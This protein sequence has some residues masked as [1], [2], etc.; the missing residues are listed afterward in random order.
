MDLVVVGFFPLFRNGS[1]H[2]YV[3]AAAGQQTHQPFTAESAQ[4]GAVSQSILPCCS[5]LPRGLLTK[6]KSVQS[7]SQNHF[8]HL[9]RAIA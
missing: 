2:L 8:I 9:K 1:E 3:R 5:D 7:Q 6:S 4:A